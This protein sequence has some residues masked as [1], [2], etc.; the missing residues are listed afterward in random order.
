MLKP[1]VRWRQL[2]RK[3][4][5]LK[6][7]Q[8]K[9]VSDAEALQDFELTIRL[10]ES[11]VDKLKEFAYFIEGG[12]SGHTYDQVVCLLIKRCR[13]SSQCQNCKESLKLSK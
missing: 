6:H 4:P 3:T 1:Y 13:V 2:D 5:T 12:N 9:V 10:R 8:R 11:T 7:A